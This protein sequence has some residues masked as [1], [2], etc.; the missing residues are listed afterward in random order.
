MKVFSNS[1]MLSMIIIIST[2]LSCGSRNYKMEDYVGVY[3]YK[4]LYRKYK[5]LNYL[6]LGQ[7][8]VYKHV[9][10]SKEDTLVH[11]G[12]WCYEKE[13]DYMCLR[14]YDWIMLGKGK[15]RAGHLEAWLMHAFYESPNLL[16]FH[17]DAD[18]DF[19]RVDSIEAAQLGIKEDSLVW[20][21]N[22]QKH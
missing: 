17:P 1:S 3:Y 8:S 20:K 7:D 6:V 10:V 4:Y 5:D 11:R 18:V 12:K 16:G 15:D 14:F 9:Y 2:S 13:G 19:W 21:M 22:G